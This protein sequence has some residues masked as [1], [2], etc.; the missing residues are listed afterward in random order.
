[1]P[2]AWQDPDWGMLV[3]LAM[4]TGARRGELCA[5]RWNRLDFTTGVLEIRTSI[6]QQGATTW[7]KD[8]KTHQ[9]RR[10]TLDAQT[11]ALL[12]A[13]YHR[14]AALADAVDMELAPAGRIFSPV[15]DGTSGS[16]RTHSASGTNACV[17][18]SA[19]I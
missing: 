1:M 18:A 4:V 11:L 13:Y 14:R 15:P 8:T 3:W 12:Q 19:G 10:I 7:E 2:E 6:A 5:L 16:S 9:Q 17:P